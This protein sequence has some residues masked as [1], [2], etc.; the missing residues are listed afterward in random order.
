MGLH[1]GLCVCAL[2]SKGDGTDMGGIDMHIFTD[3]CTPSGQDVRPDEWWLGHTVTHRGVHV[4]MK[5]CKR[6]WDR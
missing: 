1:M 2:L 6:G 3:P 4:C 5:L